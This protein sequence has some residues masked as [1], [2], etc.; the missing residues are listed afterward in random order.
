MLHSTAAALDNNVGFNDAGAFYDSGPSAARLD[1]ALLGA[2]S[3]YADMVT[4]LWDRFE[5]SGRQGL[6][7][8]IR[9][10]RRA[11]VTIDP[12]VARQTGRNEPC[13]CGSGR[14]FKRCCG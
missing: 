4:L 14:K 3:C 9:R 8:A 11:F 5:L 7:D 12:E 6:D 2:I 10:A 1:R 13:P